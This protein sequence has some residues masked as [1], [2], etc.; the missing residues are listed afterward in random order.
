MQQRR[1]TPTMLMSVG[2]TLLLV[3]AL[4]HSAAAQ[5]CVQPPADLVS[6]W[7]G[8]TDATDFEDGN[9]G[10]LMNGALAGV[11]GKVGGAFSF[12]GVDDRVDIANTASNLNFGTGDFTID[13]WAKVNRLD[14]DQTF[15]HKTDPGSPIAPSYFVEFNRPYPQFGTNDI[16][17]RL[18]VNESDLN[19]NDLIVQVPGLFSV[20]QWHHVAAVREGN[21]NRLYLDGNLVGSQTAGN[22]VDTGVGGAV[23]LGVVIT[24][25]PS[26]AYQRHLDG[27]LDE[28]EAHNRALTHT[29]IQSVFNAGSAGKCKSLAYSCVGFGPPMNNGAVTVKGNRALPLKGQLRDAAS[30]IITNTGVTASPVLQVL[31]DSGMGG[32]PIDVTDDALPVG[33]GTDGN[34]FVFD[35]VTQEWRYNLSTKNYTAAGT[36]HLLML[37]GNETEYRIDPTCTATFVRE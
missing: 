35:P 13:L 9:N 25:V 34:Q 32:D 21:T 17:L 20:G 31:F 2:M 4:M 7:T 11:A 27:S 24:G 15:I 10:T 8:D 1:E 6:W 3:F 36:Y 16:A 29:E 37:S 26:P 14:R 30:N 33:Q 12:D 28:I 18:M 22:N 5:T 23:A 19:R